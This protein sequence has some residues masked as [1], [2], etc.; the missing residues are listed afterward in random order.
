MTPEAQVM[1]AGPRVVERA[2]EGTGKQG[3]TM[4]EL[5]GPQVQLY[6]AFP[7]RGKVQS[8]LFAKATVHSRAQH[9]CQ[10]ALHLI[11]ATAQPCPHQLQ[12]C[13]APLKGWPPLVVVVARATVGLFVHSA[14]RDSNGVQMPERGGGIRKNFLGLA[15][16]SFA[17]HR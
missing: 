5:G 8:G 14:K 3:L 15:N 11:F 12:H 16:N 1:V 7:L 6:N 9:A 4:Q 13:L 17:P 10:L 2:W